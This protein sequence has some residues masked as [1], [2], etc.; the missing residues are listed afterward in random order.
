[1]ICVNL[2]FAELLLHPLAGLADDEAALA[3][4]ID[5]DPEMEDEMRTIIRARLKP[6]FE[7]LNDAS[8]EKSKIALKYYLSRKSDASLQ[9]LFDSL[10]PPFNLPREPR[11]FFILLWKEI[12]GSESFLIDEKTQ[13]EEKNDLE[14]V[15]R[16]ISPQ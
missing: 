8:K 4:F 1:M 7:E 13:V 10:L 12:F 11:T 9:R 2:R 16:T 6:H 14:E 3:E 15:Q 5:L